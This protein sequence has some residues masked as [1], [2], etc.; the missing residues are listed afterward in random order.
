M[1]VIDDITKERER[2]REKWRQRQEEERR[3]HQQNPILYYC[4]RIHGLRPDYEIGF[5]E[6]YSYREKDRKL[7]VEET[8]N[9]INSEI[10]R[11][12][13]IHYPPQKPG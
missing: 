9:V 11:L 7:F 5:E 8:D 1:T 13:N 2:E 10:E 6:W 3:K 12:H 4:Y